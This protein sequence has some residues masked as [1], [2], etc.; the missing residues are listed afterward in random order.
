MSLTRYYLT[1]TVLSLLKGAWSKASRTHV[2]HMN[3]GDFYQ[4][5]VSAIMDKNT[6]VEIVLEGS[7]GTTTVLKADLPLMKGEVIDA[8]FMSISDL[9]DFYESEIQDAKDSEILLSLHLKATMMKVSDPIFFGHAIKV[10]FKDAFEKH[11]DT[12]QAIGANPNNGLSA[13]LEQIRTKLPSDQAKQ[14]EADFEACYEERPWLAMV[15]SGKGIT[16]LHAPND[17]I[18]DAS[19]PVVIRDSGKMWNKMDELEDTK[20]LIPDRSYA[21]M[22]QEAISYV[23]THGQFDPA[24]MGSVVSYFG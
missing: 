21:T 13:V 17:I 4:N 11:A 9:C 20:C 3:H 19:M 12:L 5:E 24:T 16:N 23:K 7:S 2:A 1:R 22:Y 14:I 15:D 10:Y 8:T 18:I 6:S